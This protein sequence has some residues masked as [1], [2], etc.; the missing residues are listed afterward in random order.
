MRESSNE[1]APARRKTDTKQENKTKTARNR[2][3]TKKHQKKQ[4]RN[5]WLGAKREE[6]RDATRARGWKLAVMRKFRHACGLSVS[7]VNYA[8]TVY[9]RR[10]TTNIC[11]RRTPRRTL[12]IGSSELDAGLL[13]CR[14]RHHFFSFEAIRSN[15]LVLSACLPVRPTNRISLVGRIRSL[16]LQVCLSAFRSL[17]LSICQHLCWY[18]SVQPSVRS[19]LRSSGSVL[20]GR[21]DGR[22]V[23]RAIG[24]SV[25]RPIRSSVCSSV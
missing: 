9:G 10:D 13:S 22:T 4:P 18:R 23:A 8:L 3:P 12:P 5:S 24:R 21:T 16:W 14:C 11:G 1:R 7:C 15:A 6:G 2:K 19:F 20:V 25:N 17:C